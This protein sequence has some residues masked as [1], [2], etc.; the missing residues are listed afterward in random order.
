MFAREPACC[1]VF[2]A[3]V[4]DENRGGEGVASSMV[5]LVSGAPMGIFSSWDPGIVSVPFKGRPGLL[6]GPTRPMFW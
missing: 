6:V 1:C 2:A 4:S 3:R 5:S